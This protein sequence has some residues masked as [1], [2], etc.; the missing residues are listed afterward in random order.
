MIV[1]DDKYYIRNAWILILVFTLFRLLYSGTFELAPDET[2]YWQW[3]RHMAWGYHDQAP[4]IAWMIKLSTFLFGH[5]E[6][7]VRLPSVLAMAIASAYLVLI[8][9]RWIGVLAAFNTAILIHGI[10]L[11]NVGGLLATPDGLQA[12]AWAAA[13][14]HVACAYEENKWSQWITGGL[15]F[16]F[17]MLSKY[18]MVIF[19]PGAFLY[20]LLSK[21]HRN[22]L[23]NLRPYLGVILGILMFVPVILW[24]ENN[25]WSSFRHVAYLGGSNKIFSLH[26]KYIGDYLG[27]QAGLLSPLTTKNTGTGNGFMLFS[28]YHHL[29]CL[30]DLPC[31]AFIRGF[32]A[33]GRDRPIL[34]YR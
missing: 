24:N 10:L 15:W 26:V 11:F 34:P 25:G 20:G 7:A 3:S 14:Y 4:M 32:T 23:A 6:T 12:A 19:L 16:G 33:T 22:R 17:G 8:A 5:T 18:T 29:Q 21:T 30:R 2:N 28:F 1:Q 27:S 9:K 31:S 13:S